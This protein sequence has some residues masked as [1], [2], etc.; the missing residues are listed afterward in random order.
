M[1]NA[2]PNKNSILNGRSMCWALRPGMISEATNIQVRILRII[3][4]VS[5]KLKSELYQHESNL[6]IDSI[7]KYALLNIVLSN[8]T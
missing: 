3:G 5:D 6:N 1:V 4:N 8:S 7:G 2:G